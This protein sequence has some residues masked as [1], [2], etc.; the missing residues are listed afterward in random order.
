MLNVLIKGGKPI[1]TS[2]MNKTI[3]NRMKLIA[4]ADLA[5]V[6]LEL[7]LTQDGRVKERTS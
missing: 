7:G 6:A 4:G 1:T 2:T 3:S 5:K